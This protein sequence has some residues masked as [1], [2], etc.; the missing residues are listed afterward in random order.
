[1]AAVIPDT[2]LQGIVTALMVSLAGNPNCTLHL[3]QSNTICNDSTVL[4]DFTEA[5][6]QGYA[7]IP[8]PAATDQGVTI[9]HVDVWYYAPVSFLSSGP[10]NIPQTV[11]GYWIQWYD[12]GLGVPLLCWC[13]A[14][15]APFA[16]TAFPQT[17][18][19][20]L[21]LGAAQG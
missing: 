6:F 18:S 4:S 15:G 12:A 20:S 10:A 7:S 11:Y 9:G 14:W 2:G 5:T 3:F 1:M 21:S 16:F 17:L 8:L 13:E 19:F